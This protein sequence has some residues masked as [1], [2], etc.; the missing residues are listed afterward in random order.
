MG[1]LDGRRR[2]VAQQKQNSHNIV[3]HNMN[4]SKK[5]CYSQTEI[6]IKPIVVVVVIVKNQPTFCELY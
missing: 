1:A 5:T 2:S 4:K 6:N 3:P